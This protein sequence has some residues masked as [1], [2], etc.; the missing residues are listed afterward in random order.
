MDLFNDISHSQSD[1]IYYILLYV[2]PFQRHPENNKPKTK[3]TRGKV[4]TKAMENNEENQ[5]R[6][7][8]NV[9]EACDSSRAKHASIY[10]ML[11][12]L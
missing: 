11:Y 1:D 7:V 8:E 4:K 5:S 2:I 12:L 6:R 9:H 3:Q 10:S